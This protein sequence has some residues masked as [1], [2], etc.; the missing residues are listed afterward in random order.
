MTHHSV[1]IHLVTQCNIETLSEKV[2]FVDLDMLQNK[3]DCSAFSTSLLLQE[4]SGVSEIVF[5]NKSKFKELHPVRSLLCKKFVT[6]CFQYKNI[7]ELY[8][9]SGLSVV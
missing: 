8:F 9:Y 1:E 4:H 6:L 5:R 2:Q 7:L 3:K